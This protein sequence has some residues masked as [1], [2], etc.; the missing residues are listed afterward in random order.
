VE[1][2]EVLNKGFRVK[3]KNSEHW[4]DQW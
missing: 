2:V 4:V 1:E 3:T